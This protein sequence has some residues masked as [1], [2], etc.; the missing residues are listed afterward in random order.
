MLTYGVLFWEFFKI[1]LFAVGG[2]MVTIPFLFDLTRKFDWFTAE[3][4]TNMIAVSQSTPGPV[5][6]N[7][8]TYAGFQA[9]GVWG[10]IIATFGLALPS[11]VIV[12]WISKL[13]KRCAQNPLVCE[14]MAAIRP[15]VVAL[16][17]LAG[18]ELFKLSVTNYVS[19]VFAAVFFAMVYFYNGEPLKKN[20]RKFN[21]TAVNKKD[22]LE[23]MKEVLTRRLTRLK[24]E[25]GIMPDLIILDGG[26]TQLEVGYNVL[27]ELNINIKIVGLFKTDKHRTSGLIDVDGNTYFFDDNKPLFFMLTRMQDEVHRYAITTHIKKRNKSMF[28]SIYSGIKGLG[29]KKI[30]LLN[31]AFPNISELKNATIEELNQILPKEIAIQ[32]LEK[33][34]KEYK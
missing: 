11:M 15:A 20:Y 14:I 18:A 1:G 32:L 24:E 4:L 28:N 19:G 23:S 7:M 27:K 30:E 26:R 12:I 16:I 9:A 29:P 25:N 21:I 8:A 34:K 33:I 13:L 5:G 31:K 17:L 3:E 6:V 22:D 2:G 10:G